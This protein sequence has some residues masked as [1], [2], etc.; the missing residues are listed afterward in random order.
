MAG[1]IVTL[2]FTDLA[3]SS[4][5]L[6]RLGDD[7]AEDMRRR[8]FRILRDAVADAGGEEVKNLGDGLM[9]V[10]DSGT[11]AT[12]CAI[13][14][15]RSIERHNTRDGPRLGVR[16]GL[17][18]G[19]PARDEDDFFGAAVVVAKRLCDAAEA[20]Q[21][22]ASHLVRGLVASKSGFV[23]K[24]HDDVP[25]KG[26]DEPVGAFEVDWG[27]P[28]RPLRAPGPPAVGLVGR[29]HQL[30]HLDAQM[31]EAA[32]GRLRAVLLLGD[33]GVGKTRLASEFALRHA[34]GGISLTARA[35]PLGA[36]SSLGLWVEALE[37][38][39]RAFD[40][41][42]IVELCGG[43]LN[44][45]AALLPS[46]RA[47][48]P[49]SA[50]LSEPPR[51][52]L[53]GAL[54]SL[55]DRLA[56]RSSVVITLDDVHL[57]DGSSWEALNYLARN[58]S[59]SRVLVIL[60]ARSSELAEHAVAGDVVRGLE[61]E[62]LLTRIALNPLS[63]DGV[64]EL[65]AELIHGPVPD[66]LVEWLSERAEGSPLFVTGLV[67]AL[68]EEGADLENP[69]LRSLPEDLADRVE[70]R[71][72][73]LDSVAR[74][75]LE[76]L[77][78]IAYRAELRDL[79]RLTNQSLDDL[80]VIL[81]GLQRV[82]LVTELE[83]GREL[84]YEIAHPLIQEAIYRQIGG[85][86]RRAL[87]RHVARVLVE[88]GSYGTAASHVVQAADPGDDEAVET[89]CEALRRAEA[90][91]HHREALALL[92]ALIEMVPAGDRRWLRVLEVMPVTPDWVVDHRADANADIG[93]R[94][95]RRAEQV[96]DRVGDP[97]HRAAVKFSL[98]SLLAWGMCDLAA[99]R[100]LVQQARQLFVEAGDARSVLVATNEL[101]Y[102]AAMIDD[103]EAH[104]KLAREVLA[105]ATGEGAVAGSADPA[106]Q[107]QALSSL[108]WALQLSGRLEACL[109]VIEQAIDVARAADKT[110]RLC[111]LTSLLAATE[112]LLGRSH[113]ADE[114][115]A[116]KDMHPAYRD[117]LLLDFKA[118]M[119]WLDG[120]LPS[121]VAACRDQMAWDGGLS[122]RRA[123][124]A[125]MA[126][127]AL[128]ELGRHDE[129]AAIQTTIEASFRGR[130]CW[131][132]S[133]LTA[134]AGAVARLLS[135]DAAGGLAA[136]TAVCE[137]A[138]AGGYWG[139]GRWM[140]VD[141][142]E[143]AAY[144]GR[145][146]VA[147]RAAELLARDP[148]PPGGPSHAA[149]RALVTATCSES[150]AGGPAGGGSVAAGPVEGEPLLEEAVAGFRTAGWPL[151]EA[152]A[153]ALLGTS[154]A[155]RDR[156]RAVEVL[157]S[158]AELFGSHGAVARRDRVLATLAG[159]GTK[160]RRK[161]TELAGPGALTA[162][163]R[164]VARLAA[165]GY[166]AREIAGRLFI[167]DRTVET[168]LANAY[169]KLGVASKVELVRRSAELDL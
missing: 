159:L 130:A 155:Q 124:G 169:A 142:A 140:A 42:D 25:L 132:L 62:G 28:A 125:G 112:H 91:E 58:L 49:A 24:P 95:M 122:T 74:A 157:E 13:A 158:A 99:G 101:G 54:A 144:A 89:L 121:V 7:G 70:T 6:Q 133:R 162:R 92:E 151:H 43:Q 66:A 76:M 152:R 65:A 67:R 79:L 131:V 109:P 110:Y 137:D 3:G 166:S 73:D 8:H 77:A 31:E 164:E 17:H 149:A 78:V 55:I 118:Q 63:V 16:V 104:E 119:A 163:E 37:R 11:A 46:A 68:L 32:A 72:R 20:G 103:G 30:E 10:F 15:Q 145:A 57:A 38:G 53:L 44:D 116:V 82:R 93:V 150:L 47:A 40:P 60:V 64:R 123:F 48:L 2:L 86:R 39:L 5:L 52:R 148:W 50:V 126:V 56:R 107:L 18:V 134:W 127:M 128:A 114:L 161:R 14:M 33:A 120:D 139:W 41:D 21:I 138:I 94:A 106:L 12:R 108:A 105:V 71:L 80:A 160:G 156:G 96:L 83:V 90:G 111:Y 98:G 27:E 113:H 45:L 35:Y 69:S 4:A 102:H 87:H 34:D 154:L 168:H 85:A 26:M 135:G 136:L 84:L 22:L 143:A 97:G 153:L 75:T 165:E 88:A 129:A 115:D 51:I 81:E 36:T 29:D 9:V 19:E 141:L 167:G 147:G 146:E 117:T 100:E 61:Q 59:D 1:Q 23:F